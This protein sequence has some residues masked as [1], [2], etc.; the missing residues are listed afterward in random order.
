MSDRR[1]G[2]FICHCGGNISDYVDVE[3]V[4]QEVA[5]EDGVIVAETPMFACSDASQQEMIDA[6]KEQKLDGLVVASCSPKLHLMTFRATAERAGLNPY[7]YVQVNLREQDSWA[8]RDDMQAATDKGIRLVKAGVAKA[9]LS[10][11]LKQLRIET[12]PSVLVIGAGVAGLR[13]S[14]ALSDMGLSVTLIEREKQVGGWTAT[15]GETFPN[16]RPGKELVSKLE[17]DVRSRENI[18]LLTECELVEKAGSIGDFKLKLRTS[19]GEETSINVGAIVVATGFDNYSP[20]DGEYGSGLDG[21]ITLPEFKKIVDNSTGHIEVGGKKINTVAYIYCVGSRQ[22]KSELHPKPNTYCSRYCCSSAVHTAI[23]V[24]RVDPEVNQYHLFRDMRTY[25]KYELLYEKAGRQGSVFVRFDENNQPS[26]KKEGS[27]LVVT[28]VDRLTGG[29]EIAIGADLVVL[30]TGMVPRQNPTLV[31]VLKLPLG[32][33]GFFNEI[34]P[35]LRPVETVIDG[36][37]IVGVAQGPK[38]IAESVASALDGVAKSGAL[39]LKGY[40]DLEPFIAVVDQDRCTWCGA[41]AEACP[42][43]AIEQ[44]TID[45]KQVAQIVPSL[46][47][48]GGPCVPVCEEDAID[49]KGYTDNQITATID[50]LIRKAM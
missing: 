13:A 46:C 35:K 31:D 6:I 21:V 40:V 18:N 9:K 2:V 16:D 23:M 44:V 1:I 5:K 3:R 33:D 38:S 28:A 50:A 26:V 48:G 20:K 41:C 8:H 7:R 43:G 25:G 17:K 10:D 12:K 22:S 47:K 49:L 36:V 4:K 24:S 37:F 19:G 45:G 14:L 11:P 34:H 15:L 32:R 39:L 30:V 29:D 42:Y 27:E